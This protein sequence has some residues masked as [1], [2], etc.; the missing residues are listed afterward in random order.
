MCKICLIFSFLIIWISFK[1]NL[2]P[3]LCSI[4][5]SLLLPHAIAYSFNKLW[6]RMGSHMYMRFCS[7]INSRISHQLYC[8]KKM[9]VTLNVDNKTQK[10]K[11]RLIFSPKRNKSKKPNIKLPR[12]AVT[13]KVFIDTKRKHLQ[14]EIVLLQI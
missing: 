12:E 6:W 7:F 2:I 8:N 5:F 14:N 4:S 3:Q 13:C 1:M 9:C 10:R 11:Q